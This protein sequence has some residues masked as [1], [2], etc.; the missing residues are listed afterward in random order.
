STISIA[1]QHGQTGKRSSAST[2]T[3]SDA[4]LLDFAVAWWAPGCPVVLLPTR[5]P[6][7]L[8]MPNSS[9]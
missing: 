1:P 7:N 3:S 8:A 9:T 4:A 2:F 5:R 6:P